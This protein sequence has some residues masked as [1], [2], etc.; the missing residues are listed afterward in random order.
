MQQSI[1]I[2]IARDRLNEAAHF[3]GSIQGLEADQ[4]DFLKLRLA[5]KI[6]H[7]SFAIKTISY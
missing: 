2:Y 6:G 5:L 1:H 3:T 7:P 4:E